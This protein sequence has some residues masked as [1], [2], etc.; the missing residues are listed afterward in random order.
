MTGTRR[1]LLR[2]VGLAAA[3]GA[4]GCLGDAT[5]AGGTPTRTPKAGAQVGVACDTAQNDASF[6][7][8]VL[9]VEPGATVTWATQ[10]HCAQRVTAYHPE[11]DRP[12]RMPE[13]ATPFRSDYMRETGSTFAHTFETEG[14]YDYAGVYAE[15]G[16]VGTVVVGRPDPATQPGLAEP[17]ESLAPPVRERIRDVNERAR[18]L[19]D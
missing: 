18:E 17:Q 1:E 6:T 7:P 13:S 2:A 16:Q 4:A 15:D 3:A 19:L 9:W 5:G 8:D 14:V 11:Y 10:S 12:L